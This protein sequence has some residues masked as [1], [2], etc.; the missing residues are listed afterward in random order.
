MGEEDALGV[1]AVEQVATALVLLADPFRG[2]AGPGG[3]RLMHL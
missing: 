3:R 1:E 2:L